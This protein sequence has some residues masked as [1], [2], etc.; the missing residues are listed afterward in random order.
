MENIHPTFHKYFIFWLKDFQKTAEKV[1]PYN[2]R[3][4][5]YAELLP[6]F[7]SVLDDVDIYTILYATKRDYYFSHCVQQSSI[8]TPKA[9]AKSC[10]TFINGITFEYHIQ[11]FQRLNLTRS[12]AIQCAKRFYIENYDAINKKMGELLEETLAQTPLASSYFID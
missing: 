6:D 8:E 2:P 9:L 5:Q 11:Q 4:I 10:H 1:R 12:Q 3:S 7:I